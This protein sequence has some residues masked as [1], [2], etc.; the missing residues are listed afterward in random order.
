MNTRHRH[1]GHRPGWAGPLGRRLLAGL[2]VLSLFPLALSNGLGYWRSTDIIEGTIERYLEGIADLQGLHV[3]GQLQQHAL[4][5]REIATHAELAALL[6]GGVPERGQTMDADPHPLLDE[7]LAEY[8]GFDALYV[9]T[10]EGRIIASA[11][12]PPE[13]IRLWIGPPLAAPDGIVEVVRESTPPRTPRVR[14]AVPLG[15]GDT[16]P[17]LFV[18]GTIQVLGASEFLHIPEH[19]A[20]TVETFII[21]AG[22]TPIFVSHP[23]SIIDYGA[24]FDTPLLRQPLRSSVVYPDRQGVE[25]IGTM[26]AVPD[27]PWRLITEVPVSDAL[28]ELRELRGV[29]VWLGSVLALLVVGLALALAARIVAPVHHLVSATR[30][31][32]AGDLEARVAVR[33]KDE[34]GELG[35]AFNEMAAELARTSARVEEL[36]QHEIQRAGQLATVGEL[37]SGV[38][39]EIKNPIQGISGGLDLVMRHAPANGEIEPIVREMRRQVS[40]VD[41]AVR[42]LLAFARPA[43][44][45]FAPT[46]LN[47]VVERALTLVRPMAE[48]AG[49]HI[50]FEVREVVQIYADAEMIGQSLVNL[51]V[52]AVQATDA[53]GRVTVTTERRTDHAAIRIRDTGKGMSPHQV[54]Q[55]FK[56]FFTTK[57]QGTGLGLSITRGIIER[58]HGTI[59]V[60]SEI[61]VGTAFTVV[62]P[63][64][65][66]AQPESTS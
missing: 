26:V 21:D 47:A 17:P 34:I 23:H 31:L 50:E 61:G 63:L 49:V 43:D 48:T 46:D 41:L 65:E 33:G 15:D 3:S 52:N 10:N 32:A 35:A 22:D 11:P 51:M 7:R 18:G 8:P 12:L 40:R 29:S 44:P 53:G 62:L 54:D 30:R 42:D 57:H 66:G 59:S 20:G 9:F 45:N 5:L 24:P 25:V 58:H 37:A 64:G 4:T 38:A 60:E 36:H 55:V 16:V 6:D 27:Y 28:S 14:L 13:D 56:P 39:H 2:L 19:T 1:G